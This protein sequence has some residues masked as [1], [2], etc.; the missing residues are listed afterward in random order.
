MSKI[1]TKKVSV[2][3][4]LKKGE[5]IKD[6][7]ILTIANEGKQ[8]EGQFGVQDMFLVKTKDGKEGNVSFNQTSLN[9]CI[10]AYGPDAVNWIGKEVKAHSIKQNVAGKF[11][12][13]WYFS[14]PEAELTENGFV[15]IDK[16]DIPIIEDAVDVDEIPF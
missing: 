15:L 6:G 4:F 11:L 12:N 7:D 3:A 5:D 8:I 16:T 14:H 9:G 13:V 2:G 1:Y 10:D